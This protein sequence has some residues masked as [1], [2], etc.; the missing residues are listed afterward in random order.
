MEFKED[1]EAL[2]EKNTQNAN[3][4]NLILICPCGAAVSTP[5]N[6]NQHTA[7]FHQGKENQYPQG[8]VSDT[9]AI[10]DI[11]QTCFVHQEF[12]KQHQAGHEKENVI[13]GIEPLSNDSSDNVSLPQSVQPHFLD[14]VINQKLSNSAASET[15][16]DEE[17]LDVKDEPKYESDADEDYQPEVNIKPEMVSCDMPNKQDPTAKRRKKKTQL[18]KCKVCSSKFDDTKMLKDHVLTEHPEQ[19][20]LLLCQ[21][22]D[23]TSFSQ[24]DLDYHNTKHHLHEVDGKTC[25]VCNKTFDA[26]RNAIAH[27]QRMHK[28]RDVVCPMCGLEMKKYLLPMH[29]RRTHHNVKNQRSNMPK[30]EKCFFCGY[31]GTKL[32]DHLKQNHPVPKTSFPC[33]VCDAELGDAFNLEAHH[34]QKHKEDENCRICGVSLPIKNVAGHLSAAHDIGLTERCEYC[35]FHATLGILS[36]HEEQEHLLK[37]NRQRR[38]CPHCKLRIVNGRLP[39]HMSLW[40]PEKIE[41]FICHDC[42]K[43]FDMEVFLKRHQSFNHDPKGFITCHICSKEVRREKMNRHLSLYHDVGLTR[44]CKDC[45]FISTLR[46]LKDHILQNHNSKVECDICH[47]VFKTSVIKQHKRQAHIIGRVKCDQCHMTFGNKSSVKQHVMRVH[48]K[49]KHE[50]KCPHCKFTTVTKSIFE[51]HVNAH[52]GVKPHSCP[53]CDYNVICKKHLVTHL[54]KKHGVTM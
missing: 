1:G 28:P 38:S 53:Y 27:A 34:K 24:T 18:I 20:E 35:D 40:H 41:K 45:D 29:I 30:E 50:M 52:A 42:G 46:K 12:L 4:L 3:Y 16:N 54:K 51:T 7:R 9:L 13:D 5:E 2:Q 21:E 25:L 43:V 15:E 14:A 39:Y 31:V 48:E 11:C 32:S 22:C 26:R 10:C 23:Y 47:E 17:L 37:G 8:V 6:F 36:K 33:G 44:K 19:S 49:E